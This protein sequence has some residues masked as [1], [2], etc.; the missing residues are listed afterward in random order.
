MS[1][2]L[3]PHEVA[4]EWFQRLWIKHDGSVI[5]EL[6][7]SGCRGE[8]EGGHITHGPEEF[9]SFHQVML[10]TLPDIRVEVVEIVAEGTQVYTRWVA[11]GTHKGA[12]MGLVPT[13]EE[14]MFR[15]ITW[16]TVIDGMITAGGD[17]WNQGALMAQLQAKTL[18][19]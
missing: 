14:V 9:G 19:A 1:K 6:M 2:I 15:G 8:L 11:R 13:E 18:P 17:C 5:P 10:G 3:S 7:A 16:M 12:A 4:V